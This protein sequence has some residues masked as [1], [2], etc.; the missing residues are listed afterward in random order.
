[1][2]PASNNTPSSRPN[3][4][5][6]RNAGAAAYEVTFKITSPLQRL[7]LEKAM[8]MAQ[9]LEAVGAAAPW[10]HVLDHLE[11]AAVRKGRDLTAAALQE[12]AQQQIEAQEKK[13]R[14]AAAPAAPCDTPKEKTCVAG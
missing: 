14:S 11:E 12:A 7:V 6:A 4:R 9:E 3:A 8:L 2:N 1:M 10:G 5:P 13:R